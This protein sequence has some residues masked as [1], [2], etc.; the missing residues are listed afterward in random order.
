MTNMHITH[1]DGATTNATAKY[2]RQY[3]IYVLIIQ[4]RIRFPPYYYQYHYYYVARSFLVNMH[5]RG[6]KRI[7]SRDMNKDFHACIY[8][9]TN[10]YIDSI[11]DTANDL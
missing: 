1:K 11:A 3:I 7:A 10:I 4:S 2:S 9:R 6:F 5:A 8:I